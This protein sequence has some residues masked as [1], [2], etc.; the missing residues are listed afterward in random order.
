MNIQSARERRFASAVFGGAQMG[1]HYRK[2]RSYE[3]TKSAGQERDK[4]LTTP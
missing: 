1:R 3:A 2:K 4:H